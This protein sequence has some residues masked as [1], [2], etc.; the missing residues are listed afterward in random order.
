M[1]EA[2]SEREPVAT[3]VREVELPRS[4][5]AAP[6]SALAAPRKDTS[7][8]RVLTAVLIVGIL[9]AGAYH[10]VWPHGLQGPTGMSVR[11][12]G[13]PTFYVAADGDD[14][15]A[16][17]SPASAWRTLSQADKHV[18]TPGERLL[19][20][21]GA[22][23]TGSLKFRR[24]E[25]GDPAKPVVL[26]SYGEG[27]ATIV[28]SGAP[29]V[30]VYDT[31]GIEIRDL[32]LTGGT[33]RDLA[34]SGISLFSDL[35]KGPKLRHVS[36]SDVDVSGFR[37]GV[38]IGGARVGAGFRDVQ[39][40]DSVLHG[41]R[42]DGLSSYGPRFNAAKPSYAN[43]NVVV[44]GVR[45]FANLGNRA[46]HLHNTGNGIDLG[47]VRGAVVERSVAYGNGS[48]CDAPEGPVGIWVYD[49]TRVV[50]QRNVSYDNHTG[51][52]TDGGG[53]D[54]DQ[55][56]S[57]S[58]AQYN[59]SHNN[60]GPGFL[61]YTGVHNDAFTRNSVRFNVSRDDSRNMPM[62]A[63][64]AL[65]GR[66]T[67]VSVYHNTVLT[68]GEGENDVPALRLGD[69]LRGVTIRDN[70][71]ESDGSR[72][73]A[74]SYPFSLAQVTLQGNDYHVPD[75]A[76]WQVNWGSDTFGS[77]DGWSAQT[78]QESVG[79]TPVGLD[80]DPDLILAPPPGWDPTHT[81]VPAPR[82]SSPIMGRSLDLRTR[83]G[84]NQGPMDYFGAPL[85]SSTTAGAGQP[86]PAAGRAS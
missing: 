77:L 5:P 62:Y 15:N 31:A 46:D 65:V 8:R 57:D 83:F 14:S 76:P 51:G 43:E 66:I 45:A 44:S 32:L 11:L 74:S 6:E 33:P 27:R 68:Q 41:N 75:A 38:S 72:M 28:G 84:V 59:F 29:G 73:I 36:V 49:S 34:V 78:G 39:V 61:L 3:R 80:L 10:A 82:T 16:G 42:D 86:A 85:G 9:V 48:N 64:L 13:P 24:G 56:V 60:D 35:A 54:L 69:G 12:F 30:T 17:T 1:G 63:S 21:G 7:R 40:T 67:D 37:V 22:R 53:F 55:N 2:G 25:A 26:G 50:L 81:P 47:S 70:I 79:S 20:Q 23:F 58:V 71:F 52:F 4:R 18:F 19:L